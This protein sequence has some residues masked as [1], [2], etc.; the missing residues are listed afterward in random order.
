MQILFEGLQRLFS[1][2]YLWLAQEYVCKIGCFSRCEWK[3][4]SDHLKHCIFGYLLAPCLHF[5]T[6]NFSWWNLCITLF[7]MISFLVFFEKH[8]EALRIS[9]VFCHLGLRMSVIL[10][11]LSLFSFFDRMILSLRTRPQ[12]DYKAHFLKVW[13]QWYC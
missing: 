6:H 12:E 13:E 3:S 5:R 1:L 7:K 2:A 8:K 4:N 10:I 11:S 9:F